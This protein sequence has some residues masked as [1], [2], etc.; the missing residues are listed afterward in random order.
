MERL[1]FS[2]GAKYSAIEG[3]IHINRYLIAKDLCKGKRVLD[4]ACGEGY[5]SFLL[6]KWGA[7]AVDGID[8]SEEAIQNA[9]ANFKQENLTFHQGSVEEM[10][11]FPSRNYDLI[12]SLETI[13]HLSNPEKMLQE[14]RRLIKPDGIIIISCPNDYYYYPEESMG[15]PY[16][17]KK[18]TF[19][20]FKSM[21]ESILGQNAEFYLGTPVG[22]F[23]NKKFR[24]FDIGNQS[25]DYMFQYKSN[26]KSLLIPQ[27]H[28]I[29]ESNCSYFLGI[30]GCTDGL[31]EET[32]VIYAKSMDARE[33]LFDWEINN[34]K[35]KIFEL[36]NKICEYKSQL[37]DLLLKN[38][39]LKRENEQLH[40]KLEAVQVEND[41]IKN[42]LSEKTNDKVKQLEEELNNIYK[43]NGFKMLL[44][45]YK[46]RDKFFSIRSKL[47]R[48]RGEG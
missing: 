40:L 23:I 28:Q 37:K 33:S 43:S 8:I 47:T 17:L 3:A 46:L 21:T 22:G 41:Y 6:S 1:E 42:S 16:H 19:D 12:I 30:W 26:H 18:Y 45:Y 29:D 36:E 11:K 4:A 44:K 20:E 35:T 48:L 14:F 9:K 13:E 34:F 2:S 39:E 10:G 15:N 7:K 5:G 24:N 25:Q 27:D 31:L 38:S 32:A